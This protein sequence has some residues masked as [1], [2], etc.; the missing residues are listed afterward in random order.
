MGGGWEP[1]VMGLFGISEVLLNLE[2][3]IRREI[4]ETR[5]E[6]SCRLPKIGGIAGRFVRGSLIGVCLGILPGGGE[7]VISSFI[8]YAVE[9]RFSKIRN[10]SERGD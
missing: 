5:S 2:Q 6:G 7:P 8:S 10:S 9:K 3:A 4:F 1:I